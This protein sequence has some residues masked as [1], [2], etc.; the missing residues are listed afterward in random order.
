MSYNESPDPL[1]VLALMAAAIGALFLIT[2]VVAV[3]KVIG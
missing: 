2:F 1:D 3:V